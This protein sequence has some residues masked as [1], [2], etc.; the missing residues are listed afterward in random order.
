MNKRSINKNKGKKIMGLFKWAN[1]KVK[2]LSFIDVK[3]VAF[4]GI[5][6]GLILAKLSPC[7]LDIN[8]WW[9]VVIGALL[10]LKV[11]YVILFKK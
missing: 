5:C 7:V 10:L 1:E 6:I 2:K 4:V 11:Y 9:F 3:L 8:I